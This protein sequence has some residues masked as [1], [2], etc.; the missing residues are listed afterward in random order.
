MHGIAFTDGDE[1]RGLSWSDMAV[2]LRS[3]RNNGT[4]I[5]DA[6][7]KANIP[8]VVSGL[9]N[10]F[11]TEEACAARDLFYFVSGETLGE[12][13][14]DGTELRQAWEQA[15]IG[16]SSQG[17]DT[18][19][20]YAESVRANLQLKEGS[21]APSI[22]YMYLKFLELLELREENVP[23]QRG[24]T[25]LFNLGRFSE[26]ITDWESIHYRSNPL[27]SFQGFASFLHFQATSSYS[28][29]A[30]DVAYATPDAVQVMTVHQAKGREWPAVFLP[31]LLRNRFPLPSK[32]SQIWNL[33]PKEAVE[34]AERYDGSV[35]E[36]R[37]FYVAM[38]VRS[39]YT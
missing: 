10:L 29:G 2:L 25:V 12:R 24:E 28:E 32:R 34:S 39:S 6:M 11:E 17:L 21:P 14:V 36:R 15:R 18:A 27:D 33:I 16:L 20:D 22:Q 3:V 31:A 35:A 26:V 38:E 9:M 5:I 13:K 8:F 23:N 19:L 1:E 4:P 7:K 30:D 37:L